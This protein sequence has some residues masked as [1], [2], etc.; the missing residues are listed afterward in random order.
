MMATISSAANIAASG[1]AAAD[2]ELAVSA[3]N[4]ANA[5]TDGFSAASVSAEEQP[6]G[7]VKVSISVEA[8]QEANA[9]SN[10]DLAH[11]VVS[12]LLSIAAYRSNLKTLKTADAQAQA[13]LEAVS[14]KS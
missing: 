3:N 11:E 12:Q 9:P 6:G 4:V 7:G 8:L 1:L 2:T 5:N 10:T 13:L 14:P